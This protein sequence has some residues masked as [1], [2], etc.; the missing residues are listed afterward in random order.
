[1]SNFLFVM[2]NVKHKIMECGKSIDLN[3]DLY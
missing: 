2:V 3:V 1:M